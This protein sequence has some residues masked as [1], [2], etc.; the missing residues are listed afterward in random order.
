MPRLMKK[1]CQSVVPSF[2][3]SFQPPRRGFQAVIK[4]AASAASLPPKKLQKNIFQKYKASRAGSK[5]VAKGRAAT[6]A[7]SGMVLQLC[8][9]QSAV[10]YVLRATAAK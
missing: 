6:K 3:G 10:D 9:L 8:T 1:E 4:S 7:M 2:L 5:T